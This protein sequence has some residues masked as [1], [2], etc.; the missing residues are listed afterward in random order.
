MSARA[1]NIHASDK[2]IGSGASKLSAA[3]E[4]LDRSIELY[5]R[6]DSYLS[7]LHLAGAAEEVLAV[8]VR[9]IP[10]DSTQ[11]AGS[12]S[13]QFKKL[14]VA[15]S[16]AS[17]QKEIEVAEKWI[18]DRIFDA[19]NSV[20]HVRGKSDFTVDFDPKCEAGEMLDLA[21]STYFQLFA[22]SN[23]PYL[24]RIEMFDRLRKIDS[25]EWV[26]TG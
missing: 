8:Y 6:Q 11:G 12:A 26:R 15:I 23:I 14:F 5:L 7:A 10:V 17:S 25:I 1:N 3:L 24:S 16:G 9:D 2:S 21:I 22:R 18:H 13:G 20:K 19:K 4:L